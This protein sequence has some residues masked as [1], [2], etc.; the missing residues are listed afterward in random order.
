MVE[1]KRGFRRKR[2]NLDEHQDNATLRAFGVAFDLSAIMA[3]TFGQLK[4]VDSLGWELRWYCLK[5]MKVKKENV[6]SNRS[7]RWKGE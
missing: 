4:Q 1:P 6:S 5:K 3:D 7:D 2:V